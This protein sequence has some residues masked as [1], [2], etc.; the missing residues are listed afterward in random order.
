LFGPGVTDV[1]KANTTSPTKLS[2]AIKRLPHL[3]Q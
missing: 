1:T 3:C 2:H